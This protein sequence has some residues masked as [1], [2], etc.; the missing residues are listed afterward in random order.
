MK[1]KTPLATPILWFF[2][3]I[4]WIIT[5]SINL[6]SGSASDFLVVIQGIVVLLS[7]AAT[8]VNYK[9]Y[10]KDKEA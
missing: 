9:R 4:C 10:K 7:F 8:V 5:F 2:A 1:K 6:S 3:T